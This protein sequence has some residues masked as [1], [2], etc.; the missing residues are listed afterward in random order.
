MRNN[1][2]GQLVCAFHVNL[3]S[4]HIPLSALESTVWD[5]EGVDNGECRRRKRKEEKEGG[6][7]KYFSLTDHTFPSQLG[8]QFLDPEKRIL[9]EILV[10]IIIFSVRNKFS[11][12]DHTFPS[13]LEFMLSFLG[14]D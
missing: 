6:L 4:F 10:L 11:V 12:T 1:G 7:N 3:S 5:S 8:N 2:P 13:Q 9:T 14:S